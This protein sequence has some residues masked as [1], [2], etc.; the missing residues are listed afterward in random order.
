VSDDAI[1]FVN[2]V[3]DRIISPVSGRWER[4]NTGSV[5]KM[6]V[7]KINGALRQAEEALPEKFGARKRVHAD[8]SKDRAGKE[9]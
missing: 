8:P 4:F 2:A 1:R 3:P 9:R 6:S 7:Q 5:S